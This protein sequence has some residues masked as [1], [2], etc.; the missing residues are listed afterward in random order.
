MFRISKTLI[1]GLAMLP[2]LT[3]ATSADA[4][5]LKVGAASNVGGMIVFVAQDKGFFAKHG[6]N[7]KVV[8]RNN[9]AALT[10]SLRAGEID[11]APAA[12]TNLPVALEKGIKLRGVV[13][14]LGGHFSSPT[15]DNNVGIVARPGTGIKSIADLKGKTV[16]VAFGTTGDL[17]LQELLKRAG[18]TKNDIKRINVRPPSHVSTLESGGVEAVVAW[19]P[20]VTRAL[21]KVKGSNLVV[22]GG[23]YVCFC[24]G[25]HGQPDKVYGDRKRTQAFVDAMAEAAHF[26][27]DPKNA[28]EVAQIGSRFVRGM[29][30]D[31][32]KRTIRHVVYDA[33]I[34]GG[35]AEAFKV[36]VKQLIAQKKMKRPYDPAKYLDTSFIDSTIKR[37]PEW[38]ADMK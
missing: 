6:L 32:V 30:A 37:H 3:A 28:D 18:M 36:S 20:N 16:G 29:N 8:V 2:A 1:A 11:F 12:F 9:G 17:Y 4:Q 26:L 34:G 19:E 31:L 5:E 27:R 13:G 21:D 35:T 23:G 33:R 10:K 38:F 22:R 24:A 14:Y 15:S 25:M 7:A